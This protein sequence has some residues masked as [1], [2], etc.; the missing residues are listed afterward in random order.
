M[1]LSSHQPSTVRAF[2]K[3]VPD[4]P[5]L[6]QEVFEA[7]IFEY[8]IKTRSAD[9]F[10]VFHFWKPESDY[11]VAFSAQHCNCEARV[12]C[13]HIRFLNYVKLLIWHSKDQT[14]RNDKE[15]L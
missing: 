10:R 15:A 8:D 3:T 4:L 2:K 1:N 9:E 5:T 13:K 7:M 6:T 12:I 14:V 11:K